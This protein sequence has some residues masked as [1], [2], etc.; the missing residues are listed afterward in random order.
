[1]LQT[2]VMHYQD[3]ESKPANELKVYTRND[4]QLRLLLNG[5]DIL[6]V[7]GALRYESSFKTSCVTCP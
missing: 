4:L 2:V 6:L 1:M 5:N 7:Y 3:K